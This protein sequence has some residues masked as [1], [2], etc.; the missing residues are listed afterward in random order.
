[1]T[2][3]DAIIS[4][5]FVVIAATVCTAVIIVA[6]HR[7]K[8]IPVRYDCALLIGS[9]HPDF[10][11]EAIEACRRKGYRYDNSKTSY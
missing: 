4:W 1:M 6:G 2:T 10:P 3:R 5:I 9:W 7:D 8:S 11:K